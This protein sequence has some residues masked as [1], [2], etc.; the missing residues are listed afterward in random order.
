[1][2]RRF[3]MTLMNIV[4]ILGGLLIGILFIWIGISDMRK[5][6]R[7]GLSRILSPC[8]LYIDITISAIMILFGIMTII[9][10]L[11]FGI[12]ALFPTLYWYL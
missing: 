9:G 7:A 4:A 5:Y 12:N 2:N 11:F 1:M 8:L 6:T 10:I 3:I